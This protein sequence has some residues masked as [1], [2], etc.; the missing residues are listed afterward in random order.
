MEAVG[1]TVTGVIDM[2]GEA[3]V[4]DGIMI[5]EITTPGALSGL[6]PAALAKAAAALGRHSEQGLEEALAEESE[7]ESL[8][9]GPYETCQQD[10][11]AY[12]VTTHEGGSGSM[13]LA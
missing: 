9:L 13:Y 7:V 6:L 4:D 5:Q 10:T 3:E 12:L 1:P 11:Q 2:R 8:F